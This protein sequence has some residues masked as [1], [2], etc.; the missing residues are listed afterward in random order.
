MSRGQPAPTP[1]VAFA[2]VAES[3]IQIVNMEAVNPNL[4]SM[5]LDVT[6]NP[7]PITIVAIP[8]VE[9][10]ILVENFAAARSTSISAGAPSTIGA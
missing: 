8:P 9:V 7:L 2:R 6:E 4:A 5:L 1:R 3:D 10:A